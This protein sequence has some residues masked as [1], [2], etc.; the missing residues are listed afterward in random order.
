MPQQA[1]LM[2]AVTA[3]TT[4]AASHFDSPPLRRKVHSY[5][6][7]QPWRQQRQSSA[8]RRNRKQPR[9]LAHPPWAGHPLHL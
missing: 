4:A 9:T 3:T 5:L 7:R 1:D 6:R 2:A 8:P